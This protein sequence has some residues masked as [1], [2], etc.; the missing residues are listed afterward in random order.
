[1]ADE[2]VD[3]AR[4]VAEAYASGGVEAFAPAF[5]ELAAP[6]IVWREDPTF[7]GADTFV[8]IDAVLSHLREIEGLLQVEQAIDG[9]ERAGDTV[10]S[11][12]RWRGIGASGA[13]GEMEVAMLTTFRA[14]RAE[15]VEFFFDRAQARSELEARAG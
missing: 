11:L 5:A 13:Q 6:D 12:L 1:M 9:F 2:L 3:K 10:L 8:G 4:R 15:V 7:P 14:G